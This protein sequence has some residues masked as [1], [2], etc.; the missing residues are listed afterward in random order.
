MKWNRLL[1]PLLMASGCQQTALAQSDEFQTFK[2]TGID[3]Y[4][5]ASG[6]SDTDKSHQTSGGGIEQGQS[7]SEVR[8]DVFVMTHSYVYHPKFLTLDIG[9]GPVFTA[10][11]NETDGASSESKQSLFNYNVRARFLADKPFNGQVFYDQLHPAQTLSIGEVTNEQIEKYGFGLNLLSPLTPIPMSL[12][13]EHRF[14]TGTGA[15][16]VLDDE[17][18]RVSMRGSSSLRRGRTHPIQLQLA[19]ARFA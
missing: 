12:E 19:N 11:R 13:A 9:G 17:L 15:S 14:N 3:G 2:L 8:T 5:S 1:I 10:G 16:R 6:N 7:S 18:K 4:I